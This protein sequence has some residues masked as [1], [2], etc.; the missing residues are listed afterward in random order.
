[1]ISRF[2]I[3]VRF[4][5]YSIHA[6]YEKNIDKINDIYCKIDKIMRDTYFIIFF[7]KIKMEK[8]H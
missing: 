1:M 4:L 5:N 6:L 3:Y 7:I 2:L 8:M